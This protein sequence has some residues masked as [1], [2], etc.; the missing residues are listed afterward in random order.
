MSTGKRTYWYKK[1]LYSSASPADDGL[2]PVPSNEKTGNLVGSLTEFGMHMP[3]LDIDYSASLV[4]SS[5]EGHF[6]L[7]LEKPMTWPVYK[8]LLEALA[9]AGVIQEGFKDWS[10]ERSQSFVRK[11]GVTKEKANEVQV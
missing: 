6:H 3:V 1:N 2:S 9:E 5:T 8:K 10:L 11:P 7:Y 4:P